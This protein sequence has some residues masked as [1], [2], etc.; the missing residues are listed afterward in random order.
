MRRVIPDEQRSLPGE[1]NPVAEL[2]EAGSEGTR[3]DD[4]RVSHDR[5]S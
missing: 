1:S 4:A 2:A 5:S 3:D